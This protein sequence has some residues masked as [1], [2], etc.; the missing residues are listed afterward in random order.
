MSVFGEKTPGG[1][2]TPDR[3]RQAVG[4]GEIETVTLA[5]ADLRGR[6]VGKRH[7]ARQF[8]DHILDNGAEAC[9][10]LL[11]SD[12]QMRPLPGFALASWENGYGDIRLVPDLATLRRLPWHHGGA[13]VLADAHD[14]DGHPVAVAPRQLLRQQIARLAEELQLDAKVGLETEFTV[15]RTTG[16]AASNRL[17]PLSGRNLDYALVHPPLVREYVHEVEEVLADAGLPLEAVK[18]EAAPGQVEVTFRYGDALLAADDHVVFKHIV[19]TMTPWTESTATFMAAPETG[20]GNGLHIHLSLWTDDPG[21]RPVF[22]SPGDGLGPEGVQAVG[23][24]LD[25][26][27]QVMPLM[28]PTSNSYK[29][30]RP[31]S[32]APTRTTWGWDNRTAAVRVTGHGSGLHLEIRIPGADANPYLAVAAVLAAC[33]HG[34]HRGLK[35][36]SPITGN[37]YTAASSPM[38]PASL[39]K[40]LGAFRDS[41]IAADLFG[42]DVVDHYANAA[43]TECDVAAS[44]VTDVE[45]DRGFHDA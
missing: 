9:A 31:H 8:L 20:V 21:Q 38:L 25:V 33:R 16:D 15:Y 10:Y 45:R 6:L 14:T 30:L 35:P 13:L 5:L 7:A 39:A 37:S 12:V 28:L 18:T 41:E 4:D 42:K 40:A 23:G 43:A 24:L 11:A 27:P 44:R 3:L 17:E 19:K 1:L 2:I 32:F 29:R 34:I 22:P 36:P 26:L